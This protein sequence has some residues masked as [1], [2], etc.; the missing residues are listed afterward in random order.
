MYETSACVILTILMIMGTTAC[1]RIDTW[2]RIPCSDVNELIDIIGERYILPE[3]TDELSEKWDITIYYKT[4]WD[5]RLRE[6]LKYARGYE[7]ELISISEDGTIA[8]VWL[9]GQ[10]DEY[11][12][13]ISIHGYRVANEETLIA[14]NNQIEYRE[15]AYTFD[16]QHRPTAQEIVVIY[17]SCLRD[18][19]RYIV[20]IFRNTDS[21]EDYDYRED[22]KDYFLHLFRK[23][24]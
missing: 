3:L 19:I 17:A 22:I 13:D 6:K 1:G 20:Q 16:N 4:R 12:Y 21:S 10:L 5:V 11:E 2:P 8:K 18:D 15:Y 23:G 7:Y 9:T 24:E 14:D